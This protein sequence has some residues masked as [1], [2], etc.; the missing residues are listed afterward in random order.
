M[1]SSASQY[2]GCFR[3]IKQIFS[4]PETFSFISSAELNCVAIT[5][6]LEHLTATLA[7]LLLSTE[8]GENVLRQMAPSHRPLWIYHAIEE[9]EHKAV[10]FDIYNAVGGNYFLR[11]IAHLITTIIFLGVVFILYVKFIYSSGY[12]LDI[13]G[14][15]K[16]LEFLL[17]RP[18]PLR[19]S[20]PIWFEYLSPSFHPNDREGSQ[21]VSKWSIKLSKNEVN[22]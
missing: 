2:N 3:F 11:C 8:E 18:G 10:A 12:F 9:T 22:F 21:I 13:I 17:L 15:L 16:L 14:H 20:I 5:C 6:S 19:K 4:V 7:E 1:I